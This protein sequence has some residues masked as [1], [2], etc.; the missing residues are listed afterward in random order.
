MKRGFQY[1]TNIKQRFLPVAPD[2][3]HPDEIVRFSLWKL[4]SFSIWIIIVVF[5]STLGYFSLSKNSQSLW[6]DWKIKKISDMKKCASP[7]RL[8]YFPVLNLCIYNFLTCYLKHSDF[9]TKYWGVDTFTCHIL[10]SFDSQSN[11]CWL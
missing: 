11:I 7:E 5:F 9:K 2:T 6:K 8:F 3:H 1:E 4:S 10:F